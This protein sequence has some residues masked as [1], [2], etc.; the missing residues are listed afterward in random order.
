MEWTIADMKMK[1]EV[2]HVLSLVWNSI[3]TDLMCLSQGI[4]Q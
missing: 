3:L 4:V 2:G 1:I